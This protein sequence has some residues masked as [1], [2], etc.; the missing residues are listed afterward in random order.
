LHPAVWTGG[1]QGRNTRPS[2]LAPVV[3]ANKSANAEGANYRSAAELNGSYVT[4]G[5]SE[6]NLGMIFVNAL[7]AKSGQVR[8]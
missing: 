3:V 7:L 6:A 1:I 5:G 8:V 2:Y 4:V